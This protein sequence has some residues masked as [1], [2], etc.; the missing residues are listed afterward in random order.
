MF[1]SSHIGDQEALRIE[2]QRYQQRATKWKTDNEIYSGFN[3]RGFKALHEEMFSPK[4]LIGI[5]FDMIAKGETG[6]VAAAYENARR[7]LDKP[8]SLVDEIFRKIGE[9]TRADGMYRCL[10]YTSRCV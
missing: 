8:S 10:L 1:A 2:I 6:K 3:H 5:C 4:S 7:K 9:K